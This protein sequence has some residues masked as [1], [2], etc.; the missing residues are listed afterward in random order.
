[1]RKSNYIVVVALAMGLVFAL[2]YVWATSAP[3]FK[4]EITK[5]SQ[6]TWRIEDPN[7]D[8]GKYV[9]RTC[10]TEGKAVKQ[11]ESPSESYDEL[12]VVCENE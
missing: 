2:S 12:L 6:N 5:T 10:A 7:N 1:M 8:P 4:L 11:L 9:G 3:K